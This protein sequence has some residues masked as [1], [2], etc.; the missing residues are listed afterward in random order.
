MSSQL[1]ANNFRRLPVSWS[2]TRWSER[3]AVLPA[4]TLANSNK[5]RFTLRRRLTEASQCLE[6]SPGRANGSPSISSR[7]WR[8]A[9]S[10]R[11]QSPTMKPLPV[12]SGRPRAGFTLIELLVVISIIG[13]LAG[14]A[15]PVLSNA[16]K[17]AQVA[18]AT[19]EINDFTAAINSYYSTYSR[20]PVAS[21][22]RAALENPDLTPDF[23]YGTKNPHKLPGYMPNKKGQVVMVK[24]Q[25]IN[26]QAQKNN[27]E[28]VAILKDLD[29]FRDGYA[30]P[31]VGHSLNPQRTVFLG[32]KDTDSTRTGGVGPDGVYRDPWGNPYIFTLDLNG[33]DRCRD[34]FYS[35]A[36]VSADPANP[37]RGL[38]GLSRAPN[39]S[40]NTFEY[41]GT[42]MVWSM[43]PD[44]LADVNKSAKQG[45]NKDNILGWK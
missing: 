7:R 27:S 14:M 16:K 28:L 33:D 40:G 25:G 15:L 39:T 19:M 8:L 43:G 41:R 29:A 32:A 23:T 1:P 9:R 12:R 2:S 42:V 31:N 13:I 24:T 18:K 34:G 6:F 20:L 11:F 30:S 44:G 35:S 38:N 36:I 10:Q 4:M 17:K 26:E 37:G 45:V 3:I 5:A 21:D 22:T